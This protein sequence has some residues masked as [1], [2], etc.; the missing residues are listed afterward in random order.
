MSITDRK[1]TIIF[2]DSSKSLVLCCGWTIGRRASNVMDGCGK[3][4]AI[5]RLT[6]IQT[7]WYVAPYSCTGGD[8][9][10]SGEGQFFCPECKKLNRLYER[11]DVVELKHSFGAIKDAYEHH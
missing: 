4:L 5:S 11:P 7:H 8:Y 3:K 2:K 10:N 6:Y 1:T 9:W